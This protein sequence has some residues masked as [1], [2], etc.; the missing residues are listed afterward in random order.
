MDKKIP[1]IEILVSSLHPS[2][3][4]GRSYGVGRSE[5]RK[6]EVS[7]SKYLKKDPT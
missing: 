3:T 1:E 5:G 7:S 2:L 4:K 6:A